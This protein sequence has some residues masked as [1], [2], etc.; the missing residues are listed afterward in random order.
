MIFVS[1]QTSKDVRIVA[2]ALRLL[3]DLITSA[4]Q[5]PALRSFSTRLVRAILASVE[6]SAGGSISSAA[7]ANS[8]RA[9]L[10]MVSDVDQT[11]AC[12]DDAFAFLIQASI[13]AITALIKSPAQF[14]IN[15]EQLKVR[16]NRCTHA[17]SSREHCVYI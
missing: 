15:E 11:T 2:L 12:R 8:P 5:L 14:K 13:K 6:N 1:L 10:A 17:I 16:G 9:E 7:V 4:P 3:T